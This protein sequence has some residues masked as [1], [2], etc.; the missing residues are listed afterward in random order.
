MYQDLIK[1]FN[2]FFIDFAESNFQFWLDHPAL[3]PFFD[4]DTLD[5]GKLNLLTEGSIT[6]WKSGIEIG[7][8]TTVNPVVV[9]SNYIFDTLNSDTFQIIDGALYEG[10]DFLRSIFMNLFFGICRIDF[11]WESAII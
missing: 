5:A 6:L 7:P 1:R 11:C 8:D 3:K 10:T 9:I 2:N 4:M